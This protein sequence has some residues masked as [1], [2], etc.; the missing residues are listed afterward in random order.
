LYFAA[1]IELVPAFERSLP[2][3]TELQA[4]A[5]AD[6]ALPLGLDT[7]ESSRRVAVDAI[8]LGA[9]WI[10]MLHK[11]DVGFAM[12]ARR[13]GFARVASLGVVPEARR[14]KVGR[15]LIDAVLAGGRQHGDLKLI[16]EV[17]ENDLGARQLFESK[18]F[19]SWRRLVG[20]E[21]NHPNVLTKD[22]S[23]NVVERALRH[24]AWACAHNADKDLPWPFAPESIANLAPPYRAFEHDHAAY[25][26]VRRLD[27]G[28]MRVRAFV[29]RAE[30]RRRGLGSAVL[31]GAA[32]ALDATR[33][34][35]P[36]WCPDGLWDGFLKTAGF[37]RSKLSQVELRRPIEKV[38][39]G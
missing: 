13:G 31:A 34:E 28:T 33:I 19:H 15:S 20:W 17:V 5:T 30:A 2:E 12:V 23:R 14:Q 11:Q 21:R 8:D 35:L 32:K 22:P 9:S 7:A 38:A 24:A 29:V 4:R 10:A 6:Y 1:V 27:D 18:G 37:S 39:S 16:V 25:C 26:I 3:L 36:P